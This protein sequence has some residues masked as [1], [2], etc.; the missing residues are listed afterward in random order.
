ME[1]AIPYD[2]G[3]TIVIIVG[4]RRHE[5]DVKSDMLIN[6]LCLNQE[7]AALPGTL[8]M[9]IR[10]RDAASLE[11]KRLELALRCFGAKFMTEELDHSP[12]LAE[13]KMRALLHGTDEYQ[14]NKANVI[15]MGA[16]VG[17][18]D[19]AIKALE[20]KA[21]MLRSMGAMARVEIENL[22]IHSNV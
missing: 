2:L 11:Y 1:H 14:E 7:M 3:E 17:R 9:Y 13:W 16:L 8:S 21:W 18:L 5:L 20:Q 19:G 10:H 15:L 6:P 12:K 22:D 4:D